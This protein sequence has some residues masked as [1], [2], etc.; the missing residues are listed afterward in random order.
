MEESKVIQA[1]AALAHASRLR[2]FR[3]L[4]VAGP[5]GLTPSQLQTRLEIAPATLSF[6]LKELNQAGLVNPLRDGRNLIYSAQFDQMNEL[7]NYL[8][9]NCCDGSACDTTNT[10]PS[11]EKPMNQKPFHVLFICTGNSARSILA[12]ALLNQMAQG[13]FVAHSAG[14]Q[15][16]GQV[17]HQTLALLNKWDIPTNNL[18]SKS[19]DEFS[20]PQSPHMDFV[21]TVCDSAA[22]ETCPVWPGQPVVAHWGAPDPAKATGTEEQIAH[23]FR[24]VALLLRKRIELMLALPIEKLEKHAIQQQ[25]QTIGQQTP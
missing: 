10:H 11:S 22:G 3:A 17:H 8:T 1:L 9:E 24:D 14:S 15:P 7:L 23:E 18:R 21:F 12:E 5:Q 16:K 2:V 25:L 20:G 6:H 13:R 4:V 19:W